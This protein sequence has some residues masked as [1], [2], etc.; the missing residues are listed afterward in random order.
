MRIEDEFEREI[1][2]SDLPEDTRELFDVFTVGI[3]DVVQKVNET[4]QE[5]DTEDIKEK[6]EDLILSCKGKL[7]A[8]EVNSIIKGI[9][10][11]EG[12]ELAA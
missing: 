3:R 2:L 12:L 4:N 9:L 10:E 6:I 8:S 5:A 7:T 1:S 11:D